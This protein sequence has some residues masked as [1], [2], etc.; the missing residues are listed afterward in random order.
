MCDGIEERI[1]RAVKA[2][3]E[4]CLRLISLRLPLRETR[5]GRRLHALFAQIEDGVEVEDIFRDAT[6][7]TR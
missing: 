4:R 1:E 7:G 5:E 6:G 2:E 3:R